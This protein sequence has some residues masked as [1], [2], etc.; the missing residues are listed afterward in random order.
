MVISL[1]CGG[2]GLADIIG[3]KFGSAK[4]PFNRSKSWAGSFAMFAGKSLY[5]TLLY[6]ALLARA[7]QSIGPAELS[8]LGGSVHTFF[9]YMQRH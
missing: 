4:L 1:M 8:Q 7:S 6:I 3:R 2:D 9:P 5:I